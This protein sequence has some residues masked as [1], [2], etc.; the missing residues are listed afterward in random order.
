MND[1]NIYHLRYFLDAANLGSVAAAAKKNHVSQSAVSQAI[2]KLEESMDCSLLIHSKNQFKLS[3]EG[4]AALSSIKLIL[5]SISDMKTKIAGAREEAEGPLGFATLRSLALVLLPNVM[6]S[7]LK[8]YPQLQP[9]LKIGHT[10]NI[11]EQVI[12]GEI[13]VGLV[14]DNRA[15]SG[16][17]KHVLHEGSFRF[18]IGASY[19][20]NVKSMGFLATEE[21]PGVNELKKIYKDRYKKSQ[22]KV[23]MIV[24]SWEVIARFASSGLGIGMIPDFVAASVPELNL[25]E[26]HH[27]LAQKLRYKIVLITKKSLSPNAKVLA[28]ELN[29]ETEKLF[30]KKE[31]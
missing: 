15:I 27:D 29:K 10:K 13:E 14:V 23:A 25:I 24:E 9:V 2:K 16:V 28:L 26:V 31:K 5:E 20:D 21:K 12:S 8:N 6:S 7:L 18:V 1:P 4:L 19:L 22:A 3:S 17:H 30:H 11:L